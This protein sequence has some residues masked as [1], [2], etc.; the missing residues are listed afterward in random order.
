MANDAVVV[1]KGDN[2]QLDGALKQGT[3]S[4]ERFGSNV[5]KI[6]K[7]A[8]AAFAVKKI[9]DWSKAALAAYG[10]QEQE[11]KK[12][13]SV[14][15]ATGMAAGWTADQMKQYA[16]EMQKVTLYGDEVTMSAMSILAT[17]KNIQ[18]VTFARTVEAAMD[19]ATVLGTDL[20]GATNMLA[21]ALNDP[22]AGMAKLADAGVA[23]TAQ[24]KEQI[25]TL[26]EAGDVLGAQNVMLEELEG[27][28][29]G[30]A[31]GAAKTFTGQ[32]TQ[33]SNRIG[34][35]WEVL[36][37][38]LV[39]VLEMLM[40]LFDGIIAAAEYILPVF[41]SWMENIMGVAQ[42]IWDYFQ[43]AVEWIRETAV[44]YV[45]MFQMVWEQVIAALLPLFE[46]FSSGAE[47]IFG[48]L[49]SWIGSIINWLKELWINTWIFMQVA[50]ENFG[51]IVTMVAASTA[52]AVVS[53]W[54]DIKHFFTST[55][56]DL[57]GW[58]GRQ[59][60]NIFTDIGNITTTVVS[61]MWDNLTG[62]FGSIWDWLVGNENDWEWKGLTDG[63]ESTLEELPKI[64][65]RAK[66]DTEKG[67]EM[68]IADAADAIGTSF[69]E[70][71]KEFDDRVAASM[72][73]DGEDPF[74]IPE[75][76]PVG[77]PT[78]GGDDVKAKKEDDKKDEGF[79]AKIE[80]LTALQSRITQAAASTPEKKIEDE[81]KKQG[82]AQV[83][84]GKNIENATKKGAM[85]AEATATEVRELRKDISNVGTLT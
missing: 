18:G 37:S 28:F 67:L 2:A 15:K 27:Q 73:G 59:W 75:K 9:F 62:F 61:N 51:G 14:V 43:P 17:F 81:V 31:R 80:G 74:K 10:V 72:A 22:L 45:V 78:G 77:T 33:L 65:E 39:P 68:T 60:K 76:T 57:L 16:A 58:F 25:T 11:E 35:L 84:Q 63:F 7:V 36:G 46:G 6:M 40:P 23:F 53:A 5:T 24:Q 55:M 26:M 44:E 41:Q 4:V 52:L 48:T 83:K 71:R 70:K 19:M 47:S 54:E 49:F 34:D 56:P 21:K 12:L 42:A 1:L 66:T 38:M 29:Q 8:L 64:A 20:K 79:D 85:A 50:F 69:A 82:E 32:M 30:A 13:E 3:K